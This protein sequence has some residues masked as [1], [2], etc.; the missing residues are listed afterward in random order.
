[1]QCHF[2]GGQPWQNV[3]GNRPDRATRGCFVLVQYSDVRG[4]NSSTR[5]DLCALQHLVSK[6]FAFSATSR[7][8]SLCH[9]H[10]GMRGKRTA[11]YVCT[12]KRK[13]GGVLESQDTL[14]RFT[15]I[16]TTCPAHIYRTSLNSLSAALMGTLP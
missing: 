14:C 4:R 15:P 1:M 9:N 10:Q 5:Q 16:Y 12:T 11:K 13:K 3:R 2:V 8:T 6:I 7:T